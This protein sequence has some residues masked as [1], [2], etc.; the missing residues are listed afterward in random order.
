MWPG[1]SLQLADKCY[2]FEAEKDF[3]LKL[4]L[5]FADRLQ[6]ALSNLCV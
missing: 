6:A 2:V 3:D 1:L 5:K 4:G